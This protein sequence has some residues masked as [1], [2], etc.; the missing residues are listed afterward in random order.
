MPAQAGI[1]SKKLMFP[2]ADARGRLFGLGLF[3]IPAFA[4]MTKKQNKKT[5]FQHHA[6]CPLWAPGPK[7]E[8]ALQKNTPH[9][10]QKTPISKFGN[11]TFSRSHKKSL[12]QVSCHPY[13]NLS[14]ITEHPSLFAS[15]TPH[16]PQQSIVSYKLSASTPTWFRYCLRGGQ[17]HK[18]NT[19]R[20]YNEN[21]HHNFA[22]G[23]RLAWFGMGHNG[24]RIIKRDKESRQFGFGGKSKSS[25]MG[26]QTGTALQYIFV[27]WRCL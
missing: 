17:Q 2:I 26:P 10:Y 20:Q 5:Y 6:G 7:Q 8:T 27:G 16:T 4:G 21:L 9:Q 25:Q 11:N 24:P 13:T 1:Q 18:Q 14:S 23:N 12:P 3:W 15:L 19:R 22:G